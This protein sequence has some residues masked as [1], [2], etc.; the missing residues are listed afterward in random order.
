[1]LGVPL[2]LFAANAVEWHAHKYLLHGRGRDRNSPWSMHWDHHR[3][4][5]RQGFRDDIYQPPLIDTLRHPH[6]RFEARSL[7]MASAMVTPLIVVAPVMT[8]TLYYSA[9]NYWRTHRRAHLDPEWAKRHVPWHYDHHM[10][11]NQNA[12]WCVTK[13]WFDYIM[14]TRVISSA[15]LQESNPLGIRLPGR[16][17]KPLEKLA[18][19]LAPR[20][21]QGIDA[22][23]AEENEMRRKGVEGFV[24]PFARQKT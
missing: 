2:G 14:G 8:A 9:W 17:E 23:R 19:K 10:N 21:F 11:A 5:R 1:M 18:R 7:L 4:V 15:E 22:A 24:P 12:N 16:L 13:P 3:T 20:A 6:A